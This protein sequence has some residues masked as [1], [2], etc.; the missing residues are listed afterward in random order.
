MRL[1]SSVY[2]FV[3]RYNELA[4]FYPFSVRHDIIVLAMK[5]I[6]IIIIIMVRQSN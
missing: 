5:I 1:M 3:L 4:K 2:I 6:V